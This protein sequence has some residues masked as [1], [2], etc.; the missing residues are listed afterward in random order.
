M[1]VYRYMDIGTAKPSPAER[2]EIP[3][4]LVDE[5]DPDEQFSAGQFAESA[6]GLIPQIASRGRLP[7]MCGGTAFYVKNFLFGVPETPPSTPEVRKAVQADLAARGAQSLHDELRAADPLSAERIHVND[8]YRITRALEVIRSSGKPLS[9]F[10]VPNRP[11]QD[12]DLLILGLERGRDELYCRAD[13]RV[14]AMFAAGLVS[15]VEALRARG[16]GF[17]APGLQAIGYR[18]FAASFDAANSRVRPELLPS[19][20]E[21]VQRDTRH[22]V[23]RQLTFFRALPG[24]QWFHAQDDSGVARAVS[25]WWAP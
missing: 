18:E 7:V 17:D 9:A 14:D 20:L 24:I 16:Y 1:Q 5:K 25:Q 2:A 11:R 21:D 15:E 8:L 22:Y 10:A 4:H 19:L 6:E 12:Y 23:K 13:R 3:Y